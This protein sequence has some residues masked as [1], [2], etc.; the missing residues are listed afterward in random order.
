M[1]FPTPIISEHAVCVYETFDDRLE[2][3]SG[4]APKKVMVVD[5]RATAGPT[6]T[7]LTEKTPK[8]TNAKM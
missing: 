3:R 2:T 6:A 8:Q 1:R 5:S 7:K 4:P